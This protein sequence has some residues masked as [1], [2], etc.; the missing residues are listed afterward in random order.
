[1]S[2]FHVHLKPAFVHAN[3]EVGSKRDTRSYIDVTGLY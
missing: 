2:E 3:I 1:M